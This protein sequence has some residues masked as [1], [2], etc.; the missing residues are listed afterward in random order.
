M[1]IE[2]LMLDVAAITVRLNSLN[3]ND[4][5]RF[6]CRDGRIVLHTIGDFD[7]D[8]DCT[9]NPLYALCSLESASAEERDYSMPFIVLGCRG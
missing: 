8:E 3:C 9:V 6:I 7:G 5:F 2:T 4:N 1:T